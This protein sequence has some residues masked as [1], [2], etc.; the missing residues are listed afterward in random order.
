MSTTRFLVDEATRAD[1]KLRLLGSIAFRFHCPK[2][3]SYSDAMN[4]ELT[5]I[6]FVAFSGERKKI[7]ALFE[8]LG[9]VED[10]DILVATEGARY[11]YRNPQNGLGVDVFFDR[12]D[13]CHP[14]ELV[15]RLHLDS[16]TISLPDLVL[17]KIQIVELNEKDIK[18]LIIL[19]LEHD[20]GVDERELVDDRYIAAILGNDWGFY[21]TAT[22]NLNKVLVF[23]RRYDV[24][25]DDERTIAEERVKRLMTEIESQPKSLKWKMRSKLGP[26]VRWYKEVSAKEAT[27]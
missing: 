27:F 26:K 15:H 1:I 20:L 21:Y 8:G 24:L 17:E 19:F 25:N 23:L 5:D 22:T 11:F 6:D 13:Y 7:R 14:I 10:R 18:D 2:Y 4:R 3:E 16:P 12:L 9:Y